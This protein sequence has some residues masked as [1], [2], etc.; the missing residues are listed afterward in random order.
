MK[1]LKSL[2]VLLI[3]MVCFISCGEKAKKTENNQS[4]VS[5]TNSNE[6]SGPLAKIK[7][8]EKEYDFGTITEGDKVTHIF[9]YKNVG[10]V[11][12]T[13]T[14]VKTTCGCTAPNW[15][16]K[17]LAPGEESELTVTFNSSH[18]KGRQVKK[19]TLYANVEDGL[20]A[21]IIKTMVNPKEEAKTM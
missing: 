20:D 14:N 18:K 21:V 4:S 11:P 3:S 1:L 15:D 9:K 8:N 5:V 2:S 19:I 16:R 12:L 13:I 10:E 17:P 6:K 7:F